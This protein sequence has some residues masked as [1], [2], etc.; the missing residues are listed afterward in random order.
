MGA[1]QPPK[2]EQPTRIILKMVVLVVLLFG[3]GTVIWAETIH[4][5]IPLIE[6]D[7]VDALG[8]EPAV[9]TTVN[10]RT[11]YVVDRTAGSVPVLL[12]HDVDVA[13]SVVMDG[14][15]EAVGDDIRLV[16]ADLPGFG[17]SQRIPEQGTPH[18]VAQMARD[19]ILVIENR[20]TDPVVVAGV[21]LGGE[22]AAEIAAT[23]GDLVRGLVLVDVDFWKND[24]WRQRSQRLPWIGRANTF[25]HETSGNS[26]AENWAPFCAEGGWCPTS[27]QVGRR[28]ITASIR[29]TTDSINAFHRTPRSSFVPDDLDLISVPTVYVWSANGTVPRSSVDRIDAEIAGMTITEANVFQAHLETPAQVGAAIA[30]VINR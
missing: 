22:V 6:R 1:R 25:N 11:L 3:V 29:G 10:G 13:G 14:V 8:L 27:D 21:G 15:V 19:L 9:F 2:R 17:L 30:D 18:T 26:A 24:T 16:T 5:R 7:N 28:G 12:L 23:R 4:S 20:F